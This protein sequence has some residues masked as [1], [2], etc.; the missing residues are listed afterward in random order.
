[1][2]IL[3]FSL[4][5][6]PDTCS[7]S[8]VFE[9]LSKGLID[10]GDN[11]YVIT[12]TP[13]YDEEH[14]VSKKAQLKKG[15]KKWYRTSNYNGAI[16]FHI[17]VATAKGGTKQRLNTFYRFHHY[18]KRLLKEEHIEADLVIA[19]TPPMTIGFDTITLAK[20]LGAKSVLVLQDLWLDA[21][22]DSGRIKG[23]MKYILKN[24]EKYEYKKVDIITTIDN[25]MAKRVKEISGVEPYV[26]PNFVDTELFYPKKPCP[27]TYKKYGV[28]QDDFII[29]YVGNIGEA[30]DLEPLLQYARHNDKSKILIAG[31]GTREKYYKSKVSEEGIENI[32]FLGYVSREEASEINAIS[33]ICTVMLAK[34]VLATSFPSKM[35]SIMSM[36][37]PV[38]ICCMNDNSAGIFVSENKI[39][40]HSVTTEYEDINKILD[41]ISMNM[42]ECIKRGKNAYELIQKKYSLQSVVDKYRSL[43][44]E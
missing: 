16:V 21:M 40:W 12:T 28:N 14:A 44:I 42:D 7:N 29:S 41:Y 32:T 36:A 15:K 5:F 39:G 27:S 11:V 19:Q 26:I 2:D 38:F 31:N 20:K 9:D 30:Q 22:V 13:H 25:A 35:Y 34:H 8:F 18:A 37:K 23:I 17:D 10:V 3:L 33:S 6:P 4:I 1:M 24:V 43:Y